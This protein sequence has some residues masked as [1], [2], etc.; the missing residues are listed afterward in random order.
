MICADTSSLA[1][2]L[3]GADGPDIDL[4]IDAVDAARLV[5]APTTVTELLSHVVARPLLGPLLQDAVV[6]ELTPGFW[7]RAGL[8]RRVIR[9]LGL[10]ARLA[11]TLIAQACI[12]AD[13]ALIAHDPDFRHFETHCGLKL[14][15]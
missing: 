8:S 11:D 9:K 13:I 7:E 14:A 4:L 5:I 15:R 6:L 2:Y 12:D 10:K 3:D 1:R